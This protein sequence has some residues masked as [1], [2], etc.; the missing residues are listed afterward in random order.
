MGGREWRILGGGYGGRG[1]QVEVGRRALNR[2]GAE[3]KPAWGG[4]RD[5]KMEAKRWA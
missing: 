3:W 5:E 1:D 4:A 2:S